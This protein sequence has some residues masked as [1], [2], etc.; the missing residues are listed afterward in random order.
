MAFERLSVQDGSFFSSYHEHLQR[1]QFALDYCTDKRV[2]DAGCGI[3][4][5]AAY[6]A[7]NGAKQVDAIDISAAAID[8]AKGSFQRSNITFQTADVEQIGETF[9]NTFDVIVN[10][11]NIEHLSNPEQFVDGARKLSN[12]LITSSPNGEL[13]SVDDSGRLTNEFHVKE[14]TVDELVKLVSPR[15]PKVD[16]FGQWM[17]PTGKLR[18]AKSWETFIFLNDSYH[19]PL[20][21]AWRAAKKIAGK[22]TLPAPTYTGNAD[23][24]PGDYEIVGIEAKPYPW[25]PETIIAVCRSS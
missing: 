2:L 21:R 25:P 17:T 3:G 10:F 8:E 13:S 19:H 1:Y 16:V 23:S 12:L 7:S 4:Y 6:L 15:F 24:Y 5:G 18:R 22:E 11:E 20:H 9:S 14:F